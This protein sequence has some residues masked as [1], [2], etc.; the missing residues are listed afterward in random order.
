MTLSDLLISYKHEAFRLELLDEYKSKT[1]WEKYQHFLKTGEIIDVPEL[2]SYLQN[3]KDKKMVGASHIRARVIEKITPY[4]FFETKIGYE[5]YS[6]Y[7]IEIKF[8]LKEDYNNLVKQIGFTKSLSDFWLFDEAV[9]VLMNY[10]NEGE[11][12]GVEID[13]RN[14]D[15]IKYIQLKDTFIEKGFGL[16]E[17]YLH[18]PELNK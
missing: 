18:F 3:A 15:I 2:Y 4:I 1:E 17:L 13:D 7:G 16:E 8:L 14:H 5:K 11:F 12:T 6:T 9:F 10:T